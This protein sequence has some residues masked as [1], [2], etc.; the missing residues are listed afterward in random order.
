MAR[1]AMDKISTGIVSVFCA[2]ATSIAYNLYEA[3][4][5]GASHIGVVRLDQVMAD[6][7]RSVAAMPMD[8]AERDESATKFANAL[9][10]SIAEVEQEHGVTLLVGPAV[11]S[12]VHDYTAQ[13]QGAIYEKLGLGSKAN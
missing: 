5:Q 6:H 12:K 3:G 1:F 4:R 7:L 9:A 8:D 2:L 11:V 13:I 10:A